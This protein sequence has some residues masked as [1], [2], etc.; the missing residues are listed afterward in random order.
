MDSPSQHTNTRNPYTY[1]KTQTNDTVLFLHATEILGCNARRL[2]DIL[3]VLDGAGLITF[4]RLKSNSTITWIGGGKDKKRQHPP[5]VQHRHIIRNR[6]LGEELVKLD[7]WLQILKQ[8]HRMSQQQEQGSIQRRNSNTTTTRHAATIDQAKLYVTKNDIWQQRKG[9]GVDLILASQPGSVL[10]VQ[11]PRT[12][13]PPRGT[14]TPP[15][16]SFQLVPPPQPVLAGSSSPVIAFF[17]EE[18]GVL[19]PLELGVPP[20]PLLASCCSDFSLVHLAAPFPTRFGRT[21][22]SDVVATLHPSTAHPTT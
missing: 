1:T 17:L 18:N 5:S 22:S 13:T 2:Y 3:H 4:E 7:A 16:Y 20:P 9:S 14:A 19:K 10:Q 11:T 6:Q 8:P 21:N 12:A 15:T